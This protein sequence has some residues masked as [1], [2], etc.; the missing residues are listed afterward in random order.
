MSA[1][2]AELVQDLAGR[3]L[4]I[5]PQAAGPVL[6][7][8][9][10]ERLAAFLQ[11]LPESRVPA[12][13]AV[14]APDLLG[15]V[16]EKGGDSLAELLGRKA[17]PETLAR[18]VGRLGA[19]ARAMRME[20]FPKAV[21]KE[22]EEILAYPEG[23]AGALMKRDVVR[24]QPRLTVAEA[25]RKVREADNPYITDICLTDAEGFLLGTLSL[26]QLA[27]ARDGARL[28]DLPAAPPRAVQDA[29]SAESAIQLMQDRKLTS[30]PVA[31]FENRLLGIIR[32]DVLVSLA[33]K[34][35]GDDLQ[36]MFGAGRD[37]KGLSKATF[38]V[39]KRLPW[40]QINL[41]TAFLASSV[42][43]L[44]EDTIAKITALAVFLPVVAGQSGNSGSQ[45]LAVT[46][47]AL[48]L[49]E[50]R[51][52]QWFHLVRKEALAGL[53]NG[54]A[55]AAVTAGVVYFWNRSAGLAVVIGASMIVSMVLAGIA[56]AVIPLGLK[57]AGQD[58]ALS[59]T[60][61]L[62]TVTDIVGFLSFLGLATALAGALNLS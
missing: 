52:A 41:A 55:V 25:L 20:R 7:G 17:D 49:R 9:D 40:L 51:P 33:Q 27:L 30:I 58:P 59:S 50:I 54:L 32:S 13:A 2:E 38:A 8:F 1:T 47:R 61:I 5:H 39:R 14:L 24:C 35:S 10:A 62:T 60:I 36:T 34:E 28:S 4:S 37:E 22:I 44:F 18:A 11:S 48:A 15:D 3:L 19:E 12:A 46:M 42:V 21:R 45:A 56:G 57:A 31:D 16:L 29:Q 43:G 23:T 6:A 53:I 26:Q